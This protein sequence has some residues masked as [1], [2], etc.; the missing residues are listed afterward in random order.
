MTHK[1]MMKKQN[2]D[3]VEETKK[4][5]KTIA[6]KSFNQEEDDEDEELE[7]IAILSKKY[8]KYLKL[9]K[10]NN[11]KKN[12]KGNYSRGN[13]EREDNIKCFECKRPSHLMY[14]SPMRKKITKTRVKATWHDSDK[15]MLPIKKIKKK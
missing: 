6:S 14:D 9:K 2:K 10:E 7:D 5:K 1:I 3:G 11:F 12:F 13:K 15:D 4:K 8:K